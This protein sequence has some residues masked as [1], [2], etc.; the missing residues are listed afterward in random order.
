[1]PAGRFYLLSTCPCR[2]F[3]LIL[4]VQRTAHLLAYLLICTVISAQQYPFV[5][6]S[7]REGLVNNRVRF[8]FQDSKG[9]LYIS[10]FGGLSIYDGTRFTNYTINNGLGDDMVNDIVEMGEDSLWIMPNTN[11]IHCLVNGVLK[12]FISEGNFSPLINQLLKSSNGNYYAL[13]EE[14]LFLLENS[15]LIRLPLTGI[16]GADSVKSL[17]QGVEIDNKLYILSNPHYTLPTPNLLVYDL[18]TNR[19]LAF[20]SNVN[21]NQL[22]KTPGNE[23]WVSTPEGL[24]IVEKVVAANRPIILKPLP[25]SIPIPKNLNPNYIYTDRQK[26]TWLACS[27]GVYRITGKGQVNTFTTENGLTTN[28]QTSVFQD[29]ENNIWF[30]NDQNGLIKLSNQQLSY[31]PELKP[32]YTITD[33]YIPHK[34]D[35]IWLYDGYHHRVW[36]MRNDEES[37]EY[38]YPQEKLPYLAKIV[39]ANTKYFLSGTSIFRWNAKPDGNRYTLTLLYNDSANRIG[40]NHGTNDG[41]GNLVTVSDKLVVSNG[42]K[43]FSAPLNYMADQVTVDTRNRFWVTTRSNKLFVYELSGEGEQKKLSLLRSYNNVIKGSP[44]SIVVDNTGNIWVGTRDQG[45]YCL[46]MKEL[47]ILFIGHLS[48]VNGLSENFVKYLFCDRDN[49]IW[50]CTPSG[51]DKIRVSDANFHIENITKSNNLFLPI[52]KIQQAKNGLLWILSTAGII[53]YDPL[54]PEMIEWKPQLAFSKVAIGNAGNKPIPVDHELRY[55]QNNLVFQLSAPTY[56]DEKQTRFSY[57]LIGSG[58][59]TWSAPSAD[60]SINFVNLSPGAYTLKAKATFLHGRYPDALASY[61]FTVLPPWWQTWWFKLSL[62][63]LVIGLAFLGLRY[64]INRKLELQRLMLEKKRA[65]EQERTRI[66][67]DMHDDLGAGLS[68]IRFLSEAIG[69]KKQQHLPIEEEISS[70]RTY[71]HE[72]IDKMGEIVWALNEKNDTLSDLLSYTRSYAVEYLE[73]NGIYCDV[74]VP[75]ELPEYTVNGEFRRNIYLT[76]K[77]SLHNIVK[78]AQATNVTIHIWITDW[79]NIQIRDNGK[80][81]SDISAN[82][83]GNGLANMRMRITTLNGHLEMVN[84][85]GTQINIRVPLNI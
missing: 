26:N 15:R 36:I 8:L 6:Y 47:D 68:R 79:L 27:N 74:E 20:K 60:G 84:D 80:G 70:I 5:H 40:F 81:I 63:L 32:G 76:I 14:G 17:I 58:T 57:L 19:M 49:N 34:S 23:L 45:L 43:I 61:S 56:I 39:V 41:Q 46:H 44:R 82:T 2:I 25:D 73:Q 29:L 65:V 51:L 33:I 42:D 69:M 83:Y 37:R 67:T 18:A 22:F 48:T 62:C 71:S 24:R 52:L 9:K 7:P 38:I 72:M 59:E 66:A 13:A 35:S 28:I 30:T 1:M 10:T 85:N 11:K 4:K 12:D 78:H 64:Y 31:Y 21:T 77:E 16:P 55:F 3:F 75:E 50:A 54:Q 53:T